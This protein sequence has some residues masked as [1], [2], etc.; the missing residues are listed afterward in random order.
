MKSRFRAWQ[1]A[2]AF[3]LDVI[4]VSGE[5]KSFLR[6]IFLDPI[7]RVVLANPLEDG[8][9]G[10]VITT[11]EFGRLRNEFRRGILRV[12]VKPTTYKPEGDKD[13]PI[14]ML[15]EYDALCAYVYEVGALHFASEEISL[16]R[17]TDSLR[18]PPN[19]NKV[20]VA[21]RHRGVSHSV[22]GQRFHQFPLIVRGQS[23]EIIA[24]R[25]SDPADVGD[26]E[27][28]IYPDI[29][30]VSINQLP[31]HHFIRWNGTNGADY[32][33]PLKEGGR[34]QVISNSRTNK[35]SEEAA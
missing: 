8:D 25:Q 2:A 18:V 3:K 17:G 33:A 35:E 30:P 6:E 4:G 9:I 20:A 27:K 31:E 32:C 11:D 14:G 5:G 7:Y 24:F 1:P 21:G 22:Y 29:S 12:T 10:D 19:L 28:R 23:T 34:I 26:F 13:D 16:Y 15:E